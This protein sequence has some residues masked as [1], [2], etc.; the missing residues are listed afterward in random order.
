M[1]HSRVLSIFFLAFTLLTAQAGSVAHA[2]THTLSEQS[3]DKSLPHSHACEQCEIGAQLGTALNGGNFSFS[4][5][6]PQDVRPASF[7]ARFFST[8]SLDVVARGP[9]P[10]SV[11]A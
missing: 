4:L 1:R 7:A 9:P 11:M 5:Y 6:Q 8:H 3:Q 10:C 2:I